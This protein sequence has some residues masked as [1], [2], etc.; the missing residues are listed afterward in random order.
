MRVGEG[1]AASKRPRI[2]TRVV[3]VVVWLVVAGFAASAVVS[4]SVL[5]LA[6]LDHDLWIPAGHTL[7]HGLDAETAPEVL[8]A[9]GRELPGV[10][11]ARIDR[12]DEQ[13]LERKER[14]FHY[15]KT[16]EGCATDPCDNDQWLFEE[17]LV[18]DPEEALL[19]VGDEPEV[20]AALAAGKAVVYVPGV[21]RGGVARFEF[22]RWDERD[23]PVVLRTFDL[24]AVHAAP[25]LDGVPTVILPRRTAA[26]TGLE[27]GPAMLLTDVP[28][29][30]TRAERLDGV[31]AGL[32]GSR[33][34]SHTQAAFDGSGTA[35]SP[36]VPGVVVAVLVLGAVLPAE[37][38]AGR[39]AFV[40]LLGC[41]TGLL[42][43]IPAGAAAAVL[44]TRPSSPG[45]T[46]SGPLVDVPWLLLLGGAAAVSLA[47]ASGAALLFRGRGGPPESRGRTL[48]AEGP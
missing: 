46:S 36:L 28:L 14:W 35:P 24:P 33:V 34:R 42:T 37:R 43:G 26:A 16:G 1:G 48:N 6:E 13:A 7:V 25:A 5:R 15:A 21:V 11:V 4:A 18:A 32:T 30:E 29:D 9:V 47:A 10:P 3:L 23:H 22:G 45:Y 40:S 39:A 41:G 12:V 17:I 31:V 38:S 44:A 19:L 27:V 20:A 2:G 8:A